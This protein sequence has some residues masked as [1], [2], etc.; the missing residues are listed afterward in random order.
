M[1]G[2]SMANGLLSLVE[3][4]AFLLGYKIRIKLDEHKI[5]I[6]FVDPKNDKMRAY[7]WNHF[8]NGNV[9]LR[10][11]ASPIKP[12]LDDNDDVDVIGSDRYKKL[13]R[14]KVI[15]DL[16]KSQEEEGWTTRQIAMFGL[17]ITGMNFAMIV[18]FFMFMSGGA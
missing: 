4:I 17:I 8:V 6:D 9:F 12:L 11:K 3:G 2:K 10:G 16:I 15:T 14:N 1:I 18:I 13:M 7:D 5:Y